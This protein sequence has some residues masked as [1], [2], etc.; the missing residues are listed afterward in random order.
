MK[1]S[2]YKQE[3]VIQLIYSVQNANKTRENIKKRILK[4]YNNLR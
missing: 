1:G 3:L 2:E 4:Y